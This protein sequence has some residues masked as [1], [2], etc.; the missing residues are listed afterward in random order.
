MTADVQESVPEGVQ[1]FDRGEGSRSILLGGAERIGK[2]L[3][4]AGMLVVLVFTLGQVLDRHLLKGAFNAYDQMARIGL[5]WMTFVGAAMA[6]RQRQ[7]IVV[8]LIDPH[9][10]ARATVVKGVLLDV[11]SLGVAVLLVAYAWRLMEIGD[12]QRVLGTPFTYSV[13]YASLLAGCVLFLV[14]LLARVATAVLNV[15]RRTGRL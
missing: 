3:V 13:V 8:D 7:N 6:L 15:S 12:Y 11:L 5:V 9:L 1:E 10:S 2:A 14:F 4:G